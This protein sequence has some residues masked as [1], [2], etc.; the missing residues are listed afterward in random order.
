MDGLKEGDFIAE[1]GTGGDAEAAD[2]ASAEVREH[3]AVEVGEEE[4]VV[5]LRLL[6][7]LH[8]HVVD[9]HLLVLDVA[10]APGHFPCRREEKAV[11]ELEDVVL[12][13]GGDFPSSVLAGVLEGEAGD[14]SRARLADD[15]ERQARVVPDAA[16]ARRF[17]QF[18]DLLD[19]RVA[20]L[21]LDAAVEVLVVLADDDE[22]DVL[23]AR[24]DAR[25]ALGGAEA[26]VEVEHLA[27]GDVNGAEAAAAGCGDRPL[28]GDL[29]LAD[30]VEDLFGE[31]GAVLLGGVEAGFAVVP[32]EVD[33][34][35]L[36]DADRRIHDLGADAVAG[37][38]GDAVSHVGNRR[39]F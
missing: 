5:V 35:G 23:V 14:A 21:E 9:E 30:R 26:G 33:A 34:C 10:V 32:V 28:D 39:P 20:L 17:G 2:K 24:A 6:D 38:D 3:I 7:E 27:E 29:V 11:G 31:D 15:L 4:E 22:V 8:R 12:G 19:R 16:H 13:D 36:Q 25:V 1:V 37:D 18:P